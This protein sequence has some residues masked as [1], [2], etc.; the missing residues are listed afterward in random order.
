M[1][2]Q[3]TMH[4]SL[5]PYI[6][7]ADG[8]VAFSAMHTRRDGRS[9]EAAVKLALARSATIGSVAELSRVTAIRPGTMYDWFAGKRAPRTDSLA[10]VAAALDIP[11]S[12]L[13]DAYEGRTPAEGIPPELMAA[14]EQAVDR[15]MEAA[16]RRLRDEGVIAEPT[17]S[18]G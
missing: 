7:L 18:S 15:G 4:S 5:S 3:I 12:R 13:L 1:H 2:V 6:A 9:L 11:L 16:I 10:R 14:I 17:R 8:S